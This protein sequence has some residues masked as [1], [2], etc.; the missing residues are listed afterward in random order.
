MCMDYC[1]DI[2]TWQ[3]CVCYVGF[4]APKNRGGTCGLVHSKQMVDGV[5][6]S[7]FSRLVFV[8]STLTV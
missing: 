7:R 1:L 5:S 8:P 6:L 2:A 4:V 3:V